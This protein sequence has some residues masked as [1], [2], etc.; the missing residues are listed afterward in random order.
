MPLKSFKSK[1]HEDGRVT[2]VAAFFNISKRVHIASIM[3]SLQKMGSNC[4]VRT[5]PAM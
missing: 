1:Q 2:T 4:R 5:R 3:K